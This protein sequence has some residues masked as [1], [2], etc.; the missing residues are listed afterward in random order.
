MIGPSDLPQCPGV[1]G[2]AVEGTCKRFARASSHP[3]DGLLSRRSL[4][5]FEPPK[6][7]CRRRL[8][9]AL[10]FRGSDWTGLSRRLP[11]L[12][13]GSSLGD[14]N[15]HPS[16]IAGWGWCQSRSPSA[17]RWIQV[18]LTPPLISRPIPTAWRVQASRVGRNAQGLARMGFSEIGVCNSKCPRETMRVMS[19]AQR[20]SEGLMA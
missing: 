7:K 1:G 19:G 3:P 16:R 15:C 20:G 12:D 4:G 6:P 14:A 11:H 8:N 9:W 13:F 10:V 18:D 17:R 5:N 2:E